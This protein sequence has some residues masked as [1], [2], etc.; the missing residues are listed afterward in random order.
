M[1]NKFYYL[2]FIFLIRRKNVGDKYNGVIIY[3]AASA[4]GL[5]NFPTPRVINSSLVHIHTILFLRPHF[6]NIYLYTKKGKQILQDED[7]FLTIR[8]KH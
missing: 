5:Q 8:K 4:F 3:C 1:Q 7:K 6:K 2:P